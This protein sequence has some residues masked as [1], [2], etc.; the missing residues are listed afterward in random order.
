MKVFNTKVFDLKIFDLKVFDYTLI[1]IMY[2]CDFLCTY[3]L[4]TDDEEISKICY[5][6]QLLQAFDLDKYDDEKIKESIEK[7][8][9]E[10]SDLSEFKNLL[11]RVFEN[12]DDLETTNHFSSENIFMINDPLSYYIL[13]SYEYFYIFHKQYSL[14]KCKKNL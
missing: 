4:F 12:H 8:Y 13:F 9:S 6:Q 11:T 7:I 10:I 5:Q 3:Q 1:K 14:F 2:N